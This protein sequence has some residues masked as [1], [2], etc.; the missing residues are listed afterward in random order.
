[1]EPD[2]EIAHREQILATVDVSHFAAYQIA[3][4][5]GCSSRSVKAMRSNI[6]AFGTPRAPLTASVGRPRTKTS[7]TPDASKEVLLGKPDLQLDDLAA[8][9]QDNF[10]VEILISTIS[11]TLKAQW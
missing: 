8:F 5:L 7:V 1:M 6:R 4:V 2:V 11:R 3:S 10:E 9:L